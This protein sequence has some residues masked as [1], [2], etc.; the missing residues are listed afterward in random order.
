MVEPAQLLH[1]LLHSLPLGDLGA[2]VDVCD[3]QE[4]LGGY[5]FGVQHGT[6]LVVRHT[7]PQEG[8]EAPTE[9]A[10]EVLGA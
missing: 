1:S 4:V 3:V 9:C 2:L 6:E 10:G 8:I 5:P 7:L